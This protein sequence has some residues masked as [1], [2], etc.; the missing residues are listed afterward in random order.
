MMSEIKRALFVFAPSIDEKSRRRRLIE[1]TALNIGIKIAKIVSPSKVEKYKR[2]LYKRTELEKSLIQVP[3]RNQWADLVFLQDPVPHRNISISNKFKKDGLILHWVIPNFDVGSGGH[4]TIFRLIT[5]LESFGHQCTVWVKSAEG[6]NSQKLYEK[7]LKNYQF[8]KADVRILDEEIFECCGDAIFATSWDTVRTVK[9]TKGFKAQC[10]LVQDYEPSFYPQGSKAVLA[11]E[12]YRMG[13]AAI[14]AGPWLHDMMKTKYGAWSRQFGLSYDPLYYFSGPKP[15]NSVPRIALYGRI[16]T[17]RRCVEL[18]L[19]ALADLNVTGV[20]FQVDIFGTDVFFSDLGFNFKNHG[21][22]KPQQLG[23]L[24]RNCDLGISFSGTNYSL[25]PQEMMACGLP[26]AELNVESAKCSIPNDAVFWVGPDPRKIS[27]E[28]Q[29]I[30]G[31][32]ESLASKAQRGLRYVLDSS[33]ERSSKEV[34][35]ALVALLEELG[36]SSETK[37]AQPVLKKNSEFGAS[38]IIPTFNGGEKFAAVLDAVSHQMVDFDFELIIIDS[39]SKDGSLKKVSHI[40]NAQ[41]IEIDQRDFQ[42]GRTR[43]QAAA[44]ANGEYLIFLTQDAVPADKF[45]LSNFVHAM[46]KF[47]D[48]AAGFGR[49]FAHREASPFLRKEIFDHFEGMK[50]FPLLL[51]AGTDI[52]RWVRRDETYRQILHF[53]SDNNS[54]IKRSAWNM[55]LYPEVE[56][57]EDQLWCSEAMNR[58]KSK[59]YCPNSIVLHSHNYSP[60]EIFERSVTEARFFKENFG[61]V[62]GHAK[63]VVG[64]ESRVLDHVNGVAEEVFADELETR[65]QIDFK[66]AQIKGLIVGSGSV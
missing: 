24:Y 34:E 20:K 46:R 4:M 49:H 3:V 51:N 28:L 16:G 15:K 40:P 14:C 45:W 44:H 7:I 62:L 30:L 25:V 48:A 2:S 18:A 53:F 61:Y 54:I 55:Q 19:A 1:V 64:L 12:T 39:G 38:I 65:K 33:W 58:G 57:G 9:D 43:N 22:L 47:P 17:E 29:E 11:E 59:L 5:W 52:D 26:V 32:L 36:Y 35:T 23:D 10:Y 21:I 37:L 60:N 6:S 13:L 63:D 31:N 42:H 41:V 8:I 27:L 50:N 56:Y 66:I